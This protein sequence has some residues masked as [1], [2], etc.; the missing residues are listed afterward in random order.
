[1]NGAHLKSAIQILRKVKRNFCYLANKY[2]KDILIYENHRI[3]KNKSGKIYF[4]KSKRKHWFVYEVTDE[5]SEL[6]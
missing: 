5:K 6:I 3:S 4:R 2:S 1:M